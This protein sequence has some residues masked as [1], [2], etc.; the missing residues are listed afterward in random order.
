MNVGSHIYTDMHTKFTNTRDVASHGLLADQSEEDVDEEPWDDVHE[1]VPPRP[2]TP[3]NRQGILSLT[4]WA[5]PYITQIFV[6]TYAG[7]HLKTL[8]RLKIWSNG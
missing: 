8:G 4:N 3:V 6:F 2:G 7:L 5:D 1:K